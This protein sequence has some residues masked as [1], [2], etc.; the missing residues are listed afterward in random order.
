MSVC[1]R[2]YLAVVLLASSMTGAAQ[3]QP[4]QQVNQPGSAPQST[5][6]A[7]SSVLHTRT[8]PLSRTIYLDVVVTSKP[9][10][11]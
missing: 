8:A 2:S 3:Q 1:S 5:Q 10:Q 4:A 7:D 9:G 6:P 11:Q